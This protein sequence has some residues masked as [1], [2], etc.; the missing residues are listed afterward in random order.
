[1]MRS[2]KHAFQARPVAGL[3]RAGLGFRVAHGVA[4]ALFGAREGTLVRLPQSSPD[5][6]L[7]AVGAAE[8]CEAAQLA[9]DVPGRLV[10]LERFDLA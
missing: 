7:W 8:R 6:H 3:R 1:M 5:V 4:V 2:R 10:H 9:V